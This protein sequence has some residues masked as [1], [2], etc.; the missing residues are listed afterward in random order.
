MKQTNKPEKNLNYNVRFDFYRRLNV[1]AQNAV[2]LFL[3]FLKASISLTLHYFFFSIVCM[4]Y[5]G[6]ND[7]IHMKMSHCRQLPLIL[8]T[9]QHGFSHKFA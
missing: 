4:Q 5:L 9:P 8:P 1:A 6:V 3:R 2:K 7:S